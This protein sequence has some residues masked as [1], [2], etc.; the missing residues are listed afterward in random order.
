MAIHLIPFVAGAVIGGLGA[1]FY[2]DEKLRKD[3]SRTASALTGKVKKTAGDV[4]GKVAEGFSDLRD[5]V[6]GKP[7]PAPVAKKASTKKSAKKTTAK[8]KV[9]KKKATSRKASSDATQPAS[10]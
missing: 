3:V 9:S 4:S 7:A 10:E 8:K 1:Y 2:R 5:K 6:A